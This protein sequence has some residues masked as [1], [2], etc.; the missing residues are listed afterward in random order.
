M[1]E[2][3]RDLY[4]DGWREGILH[5]RGIVYR[6]DNLGEALAMLERLLVEDHRSRLKQQAQ[7]YGRKVEG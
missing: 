5:A 1:T 2:T 6:A 4:A 7:N 3:R